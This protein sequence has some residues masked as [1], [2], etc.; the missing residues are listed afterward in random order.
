MLWAISYCIKYIRKMKTLT[1]L[2]GIQGSGKSTY[3]ASLMTKE[4]SRCVNKDL[5]RENLSPTGEWSHEIESQ[6]NK[7]EHEAIMNFIDLGIDL[8]VIDATNLSLSRIDKFENIALKHGY[9]FEPIVLESSFNLDLCISRNAKREGRAK[10]PESVIRSFFNTFVRILPILMRRKY[11]FKLVD[12]E[13][14]NVN[15]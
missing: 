1:L 4:N 10:V 7:I 3:A 5:I 9:H 12:S 11:Q 6:V 14:V 2:I 15:N 13:G 8:I